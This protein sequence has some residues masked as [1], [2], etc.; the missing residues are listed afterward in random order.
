MRTGNVIRC[1]RGYLW[2]V[3]AVHDKTVSAISF[4]SESVSA[5]Q[6]LEDYTKEV[7]CEGCDASDNMGHHHNLI[8]KGWKNSVVLAPNV[9]T[10]IVNKLKVMMGI[11]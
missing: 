11:E 1:P 6:S 8:F 3:S 10:F 4:N 9:Q 5:T 7:W 2:V